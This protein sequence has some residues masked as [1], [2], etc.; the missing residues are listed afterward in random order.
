MHGGVGCL[1][2]EKVS[3]RRLDRAMFVHLVVV[4]LVPRLVV[5][6][7]AAEGS[8][9]SAVHRSVVVAHR[10]QVKLGVSGVMGVEG[11]VRLG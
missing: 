2:E 6:W 9:M 3:G 4:K 7:R 5:D 8:V 10:V 11:W 1:V